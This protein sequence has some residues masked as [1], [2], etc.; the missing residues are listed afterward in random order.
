MLT[1]PISERKFLY[2]NAHIPHFRKEM[3]IVWCAHTP[4]PKGNTYTVMRTYPISERKCQLS[5]AHIL[6]F[7]KEMPISLYH[8]S[9]LQQKLPFGQWYQVVFLNGKSISLFYAIPYYKKKA[10]ISLLF[11]CSAS[12]FS[13]HG[14][15]TSHS[16][17]P[18]F[19]DYYNFSPKL[20][21]ALDV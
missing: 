18:R 2:C 9:H 7:R 11:I 17:L 13:S 12:L 19:K 16:F 14:N 10:L 4:F 20:L 5:D 3:P 21:P 6:H 8:D 1:Y 15:C